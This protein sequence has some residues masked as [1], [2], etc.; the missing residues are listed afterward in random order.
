MICT[1]TA[2][3]LKPGAYDDFRAA[4][5]GDDEERPEVPGQVEPGLHDARCQRRE[6]GGRLRILQRLPRRAAPSAAKIRP[7]PAADRMSAFVDEVLLDGAYEVVEEQRARATPNLPKRARSGP[8][9]MP[10]RDGRRPK[11]RPRAPFCSARKK[12]TCR[13]HPEGE[14]CSGS[15]SSAETADRIARVRDI[16]PRV[17]QHGGARV[18][19]AWECGTPL[20]RPRRKTPAIALRR[21]QS[22]VR[23]LPVLLLLVLSRRPPRAGRD[24]RIPRKGE[25][26]LRGGRACAALTP[27]APIGRLGEFG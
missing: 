12:A 22:P 8:L 13:L 1:L 20:G 7:R 11:Q 16:S 5:G 19:L 21:K 9:P 15:A 2:R 6:R 27:R 3:R 18:P 17:P 4:W 14:A 25:V 24:A 23:A 26:P 10:W